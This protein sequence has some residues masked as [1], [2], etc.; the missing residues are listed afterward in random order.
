MEDVERG[1]VLHPRK[2]RVPIKGLER[3]HDRVVGV[4]DDDLPA[5][6]LAQEDR[7]AGLHPG[8]I[9]HRLRDHDLA[10]RS[11][12]GRPTPIKRDPRTQGREGI[13]LTHVVQYNS[14]VQVRLC[15]QGRSTLRGDLEQRS[16]SGR[17][18]FRSR[19]LSRPG[20]GPVHSTD[21]RRSVGHRDDRCLDRRVPSFGPSNCDCPL[22]RRVG[23]AITTG[24]SPPATTVD[25]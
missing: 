8:S 22:L 5:I 1:L 13:G 24:H 11:D 4:V 2:H 19:A 12:L 10:L 23:Q 3:V 18:G 14:L 6:L 20:R 7:S 16:T 21:T 15:S 25:R 9:A 17:D